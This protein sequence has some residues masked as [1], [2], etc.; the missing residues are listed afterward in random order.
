MKTIINDEQYKLMISASEPDE[1]SSR[2]HVVFYRQTDDNPVEK[3]FEMFV[4]ID[5]L[6][7]IIHY[8][9]NHY[10]KVDQQLFL[11]SFDLSDN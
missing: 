1:Y 3:A 6:E 11:D 9:H 4:S 2:S 7:T 10:A 5:E 8:L